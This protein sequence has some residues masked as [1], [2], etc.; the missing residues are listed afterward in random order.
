MKQHTGFTIIEI[1][2]V[3]ALATML[4]VMGIRQYFSYRLD[5]DVALINYNVDTLFSAMSSYFQANCGG[6][7]GTLSPL[8]TPVA[9]SPFLL[10]IQT[11]LIAGGYLRPRDIVPVSLVVGTPGVGTVLNGYH[12]RF[13]RYDVDRPASPDQSGNV[14]TQPVGRIILWV[15]EIMVEL[16]N[17]ARAQPI[18]MMTRATDCITADW[19]E[20]GACGGAHPALFFSHQV[21]YANHADASSN[22][23]TMMP[24][25]GQLR[26]QEGTYDA[27]TVVSTGTQN[28]QFY[29]CGG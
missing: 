6:T 29:Y 28:N 23:W 21:S 11:D 14:V 24:G 2:L 26:D 20:R 17:S 8:H 9:A 13:V 22:Y 25:L 12:V 4:L 5:A 16:R 3:L 15:P 10:D 1:L 27:G 7:T 19:S 18:R